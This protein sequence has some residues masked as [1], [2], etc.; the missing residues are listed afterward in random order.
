MSLVNGSWGV[1]NL[2]MESDVVGQP[3]EW[4]GELFESCSASPC[5]DSVFT[6]SL[7]NLVQ[8]TV[9]TVPIDYLM[10]YLIISGD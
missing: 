3:T 7:T 9:R 4:R 1:P 2:R 10:D 8:N 5:L 6:L